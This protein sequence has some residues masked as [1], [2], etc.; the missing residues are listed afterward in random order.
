MDFLKKLFNFKKPLSKVIDIIEFEKDDDN[1]ELL[2]HNLNVILQ[3]LLK[4]ITSKTYKTHNFKSLSTLQNPRNCN[5]L[6]LFLRENLEQNFNKIELTRLADTIF[7]SKHN[8]TECQTNDCPKIDKETYEI[9]EKSYTKRKLCKLISIHYI[10]Q[11]NLIS[12]IITAINPNSNFCLTRLKKLLRVYDKNRSKG[13]VDVC[14]KDNVYEGSLIKQEGMKELLDLFYFH[15]LEISY[16]SNNNINDDI[17]A[18]IQQEYSNFVD[19][20]SQIIM[21]KTERKKQVEEDVFV[22]KQRQ[23]LKENT[24][25]KRMVANMN[26]D[27]ND[28]N[29]ESIL[30]NPNNN[31]NNNKNNNNNNNNNNLEPK[32]P[33]NNNNNNNNNLEPEKPINNNNNNLEP[34]KP[35]NNNNNNNNN[36][37]PEKPINNNNNNNLE[38]EGEDINLRNNNNII[39]EQLKRRSPI[40]NKRGLF[41]KTKSNIEKD[42]DTRIKSINQSISKEKKHIKYQKS[43]RKYTN[44]GKSSRYSI[45]IGGGITKKQLIKRKPRKKQKKSKISQ[46]KY[47]MINV[48]KYDYKSRKI[49]T[50]LTLD[51]MIKEFLNFVKDSNHLKRYDPKLIPIINK[52]FRSYDRAKLNGICDNQVKGSI[53]VNLNSKIINKYLDN[54]ENMK[55]LY[56]QNADLL[57]NI[58]QNELLEYN[59]VEGNELFKFKII[60]SSQLENNEKN[61][62]E[63]IS[64]LYFNCQFKYL[65]GIELLDDYLLKRDNLEL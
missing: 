56:L 60:S 34:E 40:N 32:K 37:E 33:I 62:R 29:T 57:I 1:V 38:P 26:E 63:I 27:Y 41:N 54:Y 28:E 22:H 53:R 19:L 45:K 52:S 12:A 25:Y 21:E 43:R 39:N 46:G 17:V 14:V 50:N 4:P 16:D 18:N 59:E 31:N 23:T 20:F 48:N 24:E 65:E 42:I 5:K 36:L 2:N 7:F 13:L 55:N 64:Q 3:D 11:L 47:N 49:H 58:L 8:K 51:S 61:I 6:I 35:I 10:K 30:K 9:N 15:L 44:K